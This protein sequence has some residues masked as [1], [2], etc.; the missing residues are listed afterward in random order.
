MG[1]AVLSRKRPGALASKGE[2]SVEP[3][4]FSLTAIHWLR[5]RQMT[6]SRKRLG[7]AAIVGGM[8]LFSLVCILA[9]PELQK[10]AVSLVAP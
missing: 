9:M 5:G 10:A 4:L 7:M 8:V 2:P 6:V 3:L 1:T